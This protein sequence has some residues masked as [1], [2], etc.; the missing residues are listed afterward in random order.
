M[1]DELKQEQEVQQHPYQENQEKTIVCNVGDTECT[2]RL[3]EAFAD[4]D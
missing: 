2:K 3:V 4:C 1:S